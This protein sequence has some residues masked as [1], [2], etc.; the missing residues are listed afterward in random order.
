MREEI[1]H[2][3]TFEL[4]TDWES[5]RKYWD[6]LRRDTLDFDKAMEEFR[7]GYLLYVFG[8]E[9]NIKEAKGVKCA[10]VYYD[11]RDEMLFFEIYDKT[12]YMNYELNLEAQGR[13]SNTTVDDDA[14]ELKKVLE[15]VCHV[16]ELYDVKKAISQA[17]AGTEN[18]VI[19]VG[20]RTWHF[21]KIPV[22]RYDIYMHDPVWLYCN[23]LGVEG[24]F[25]D[26]GYKLSGFTDA[27]IDGVISM[28]GRF[29]YDSK[30]IL[31]K[32]VFMRGTPWGGVV[33][34]EEEHWDYDFKEN[35]VRM[36][37]ISV[38]SGFVLRFFEYA[39]DEQGRIQERRDFGYPTSKMP[40]VQA[41]ENLVHTRTL[42]YSYGQN[43]KLCEIKTVFCVPTREFNQFVYEYDEQGRLI[44]ERDY[45][46]NGKM[47]SEETYR[48]IDDRIVE[49][50]Y[51]LFMFS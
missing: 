37:E 43:G 20:Q 46:V 17:L 36:K 7:C 22:S 6:M 14:E 2:V 32:K 49:V 1:H 11:E 38:R 3:K 9:L 30:G 15:N 16:D 21:I 35:K 29:Y 39:L 12:G 5:I 27:Y 50:T 23:T 13:V 34:C 48:Y 19:Y 10:R 25:Y 44:S 18:V 51:S 47:V 33:D 26:L 40:K 28:L 31:L 42:D 45:D 24:R 4:N 8:R 41:P